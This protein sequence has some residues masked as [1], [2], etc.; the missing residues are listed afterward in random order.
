M[1]DK[2]KNRVFARSIYNVL[3]NDAKANQ[4]TAIDHA[5]KLYEKQKDKIFHKQ[6]PV[7]TVFE[8]VKELNLHLRK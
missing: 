3:L 1:N 2:G 5:C 6:N 4:I 7:T 8:L